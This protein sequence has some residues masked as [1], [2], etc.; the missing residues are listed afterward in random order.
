MSKNIARK[1]HELN[2]TPRRW[3]TY[4][5]GALIV[6]LGVLTSLMYLPAEDPYAGL[7]RSLPHPRSG[8]RVLLGG[9]PQ[10]IVHVP[11]LDVA[12]HPEGPTHWQGQLVGK[13]LEE[14]SSPI[15]KPDQKELNPSGR[16]V[17]FWWS[18]CCADDEHGKW[19]VHLML[20]A[21]LNQSGQVE[22]VNF[23]GGGGRIQGETMT[24][25]AP[26]NNGPPESAVIAPIQ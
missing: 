19:T 10:H 9:S 6:I 3:V 15:G 4:T 12:H 26:L 18:F 22:H 11:N 25:D 17:G 13:T 1:S 24:Q 16:Q 20:E 8:G 14:V 5:L 23:I 7:S 2:R 21:P